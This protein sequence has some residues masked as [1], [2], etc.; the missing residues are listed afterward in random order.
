M[1]VKIPEVVQVPAAD[2]L[3][4]EGVPGAWSQ[5]A[6]EYLAAISLAVQAELELRAREAHAIQL[7][8][9]RFDGT[10]GPTMYDSGDGLVERVPSAVVE[11]AIEAQEQAR[12]AFQAAEKKAQELK[13]RL[14]E[15]S[16]GTAILRYE[17]R[18]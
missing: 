18:R 4:Y 6:G 1:D 14:D 9:S 11:Q 12:A 17:V 2:P 10:R 16:K 7:A 8:L 15:A 5:M 13:R 3:P